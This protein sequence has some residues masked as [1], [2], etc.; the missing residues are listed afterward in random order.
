MTLN[1]SKLMLIQLFLYFMLN[2]VVSS[3]FPLFLY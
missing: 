3:Q 1:L 2:D